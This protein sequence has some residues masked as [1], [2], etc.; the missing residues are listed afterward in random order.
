MKEYIN[1]YSAKYD[2]DPLLVTALITIESSGNPWAIRHEPAYKWLYKPS[3]FAAKV[4]TSIITEKVCQQT[5]W[6]LMQ[7]MGAVAREH[8]F[9]LP[10]PILCLPEHNLDIG[11]KFLKSRLD[12]WGIK[13][14]LCAYNTGT[15][16]SP[17]GEKYA[18]KVL[19]E[20]R[21]LSDAASS[22]ASE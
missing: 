7:I 9:E 2:L 16:D 8:G 19:A 10:M 5:S 14:G 6:G 18:A 12:L 4:G 3:V 21:K 20:Y 22:S 15:P 13:G 17:I 1:V 11:C